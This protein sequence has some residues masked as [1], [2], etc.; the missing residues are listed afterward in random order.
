MMAL[1]SGGSGS[2]KSEI[3]ENLSVKLSNGKNL[4]YIATMKPLGFETL[5]KIERHK[6][7]RY[8]KGFSTLEI[9][10]D[11]HSALVDRDSTILL[12]CLS[13]LLA[14]ETFMENPCHDV[15][16]KILKGICYL[17]DNSKNLIIVS[18]EVFSDGCNYDSSTVEYIK[19]LGILNR[20]IAK[21][22]DIV[23]ECIYSNSIIYKGE[24]LIND[25]V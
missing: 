16:E 20:K 24:S 22:S 10:N 4:I 18:N 17:K 6:V 3:A 1:I 23:I 14:N 11:I 25:L 5:K 2:G 21:L 15:V 7:L 12:E 19:N 8:G 13:N 9:Y